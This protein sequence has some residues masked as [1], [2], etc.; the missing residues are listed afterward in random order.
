MGS[1]GSKQHL[2]IRFIV[3]GLLISLSQLS[4]AARDSDIRNTRHNLGTTTSSHSSGQVNPSAGTSEICVFCHTPHGANT[5]PGTPL[6]NRQLK[7]SGYTTY[8][9]ATIDATN[10]TP[11]G[12]ENMLPQPDGSSKLCLSCH[13]GTLAVA[14]VTNAPGSGAGS[15]ITGTINSLDAN[16]DLGTDLTNDHPISVTYNDG[17]VTA[18]GEMR[19]TSELSPHVG[20]RTPGGTNFTLP[21]ETIG[22]D[23]KVQ[24]TTCHDPHISGTDSDGTW[25]TDTIKFLRANRFQLGA[26]EDDATNA[27]NAADDIICLYCHTKGQ[28]QDAT[29][30]KISAH[31]NSDVADEAYKTGASGP[32]EEREFPDG[33]EVWQAACLNCHDT[34]TASGQKRL[35]R[36]NSGDTAGSQ[37]NTCYQCHSLSGESILDTSLDGS[38][39][40]N[41]KDEFSKSV[42]MP[43]TTSEQPATA[44][45]H[46]ITNADFIENSNNLGINTNSRHAECTDCHNPHR[47]IRNSRFNMDGINDAAAGDNDRGTDS[48]NSSPALSELRTHQSGLNATS[49]SANDGR[50]GNVASGVLRGAWGVEPTS[51]GNITA[52]WDPS[53]TLTFTVKQGDPA[54]SITPESVDKSSTH[55]TREYQLC[56]KCHSNYA[57][58]TPPSL[59]GTG[60]TPLAQANG[61]T[62]YTNV[63][64]EFAMVKATTPATTGTDQGENNNSGIE[65]L[66]GLTTNPNWDKPGDET[67]TLAANNHRSWHPVM[68]PT[69][70]TRAERNMGSGSLNLK[71]PWVDNIGTQ[72]MQCSDCHGGETSYIAGRG[73]ERDEVQG[74]HGSNRKFLLKNN[75]ANSTIWTGSSSLSNGTGL[76]SAPNNY[77]FCGNCHQPRSVSD[78]SGFYGNHLPDGNMGNEAC[79][80]CH[81]AVPHGWKNKAFLVNLL[82]VGPEGGQGAGC[83][84]VGSNYNARTIAPYYNNARV[85]ISTWR[86]SGAWTE[87]S[88]EDDDNEMQGGCPKS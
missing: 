74:P 65:N 83:T 40:P 35:L 50:E 45:L 58:L 80:M 56:F 32:T 75:T 11:S 72:T 87:R 15:G 47:V 71:D 55:L 66:T 28:D 30:W 19:K 52:A 59:G 31:A 39:V 85:R 49:D 88:C 43:I 76:Y 33:I 26:P 36:M 51:A 3:A 41:I 63:A 34:H 5:D 38:T 54:G 10:A 46:D 73:A 82:C 27:I 7:D 16:K 79:M 48:A 2:F 60:G 77:G 37:E 6:W 9:S 29:S 13:D 44:E 86:Q 18:D 21:L 68:F 14:S 12:S 22:S 53:S 64:A 42:H 24:C 57:F 20:P 1:T 17:L 23:D 62:Q 78:G 4:A 69:G 70:R 61:M 25:T 84:S 81:I 67:G 8:S